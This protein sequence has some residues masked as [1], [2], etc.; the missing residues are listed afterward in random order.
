MAKLVKEFCKLLTFLTPDIIPGSLTPVAQPLD[1]VINRVFKAYFWDLY[2]Q[3]ILTAPIGKSGNPTPP[4]RQ[5]LST[6]VVE[7]WEKIPEELVNKSWTAC[8]YPQEKDVTTNNAN[9]MVVWSEKDIGA[10]AE[11][12]CGP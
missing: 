10:M 9:A 5:L 12:L 7:A 2:D 4:S 1:K 3:Y 11:A 6:W 8:R